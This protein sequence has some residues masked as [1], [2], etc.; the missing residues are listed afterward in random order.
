M[1]NDTLKGE[2]KIYVRIK[3]HTFDQIVKIELQEGG[4]LLL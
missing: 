2:I 1:E 3:Y 4:K